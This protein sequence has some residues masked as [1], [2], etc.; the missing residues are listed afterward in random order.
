[1]DTLLP[2]AH[3]D[4]PDLT[5]ALRELFGFSGFREGQEEI[6]RRAVEGRDTLALMPTGAGKS[7]CYQLAAMLRPTPTLV[8]S[9]LIALMKDQ[10]DNL[11]P[12]VKPHA[13]LIN[14]SLDAN[15]AAR[16][17]QGLAAGQYKLL[18][19][20]P[21]RLR[22][23]QFMAALRTAE[24]GLVVID[25]VHCVS[26]WGHD[27]RPD[28]MFIRRALKELGAPAV[29]GLTATATPTTER[30][31]ARSLGRELEVVRASVVRPNLRYEV[32]H[33][34]NEEGRLRSVLAHAKRFTG[35]GII[36]ARSRE[37]CEQV[38]GVLGRN[39]VRAVHYHAGLDA[40]E[41]TRVQEAFLSDRVRVIVAT[42]AFGMGIDKPDI[43]WVI[44]YNFPNSLESYVQMVGRAGRDGE[45]STCVLLASGPDATN[46]R[47]F[48][49][50]DIPAV[51]DLR[52]V[53]KALR[54]RAEDG[55]AEATAEE[56]AAEAGLDDESAPRVLV[57]MLERA[58]L[59]RR[60]YDAGRAMTVKLTLPPPEDAAQRIAELL[61]AYE[62]QAL[63]RA[64]RMIAFADSRTCRHLQVAQFFG[65]SVRVPC[66]MCDVCAPRSGA[67]A[68]P[69]APEARPLPADI[70][71]AIVA[72]VE[73]L[74]WPLGLKG[75]V[76]MLK[77][78]VAAPRSAQRSEAFGALAAA[79]EGTIKRWVAQLLDRGNLEFF[80]EDGY[81]LI[82]VGDNPDLP[83]LSGLPAPAPKTA[84]PAGGA[85]A[86]AGPDEALDGEDAELFERLRAWRLD[87]A[88]EAKVS[89]FV[90]MT[91]RAL[92]EIALTR[93][94]DSDQLSDITGIG[95][96]KVERYGE[97]VLALVRQAG[98]APAAQGP[99]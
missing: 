32:E 95:A 16:R 15:E 4:S 6:V 31:I 49:R 5:S 79:K 65:E 11:P 86:P 29:L 18:Y 39:G 48:A 10:I 54:R 90:V 23:R 21:E 41:R 85:D 1:M 37:K 17:L 44:L 62:S 72:A 89:A 68:A 9:P 66:G 71:R 77:G 70:A 3:T 33:V 88:R 81:R 34:E 51:D 97:E 64:E 47:R 2:P 13:S 7:L 53:Y 75:L 80:E 14:S 56:L 73:G 98:L 28:Y 93:P 52:A 19:A 94:A 63:A 67:L 99:K 84:G 30:D 59:A 25:E 69:A 46:L 24:L 82:R 87:K 38:A 60:D 78:S 55:W 26:M 27:F 45:Q 50:A 61:G 92:R 76:L 83:R 12:G 91:N 35:P 40:A 96:A 22:Q 58:A 42:T 74:S 43:R 57:G 8:I 20:A 36:Y